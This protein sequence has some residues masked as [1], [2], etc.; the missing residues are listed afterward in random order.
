ML[1]LE[2]AARELMDSIQR[3]GL[4]ASFRPVRNEELASTVNQIPLSTD[5]LKWYEIGAPMD[6]EIPWS[7]E[8]LKLCSPLSLV[9]LQEG[10]RWNVGDRGRIADGWSD[11]W[12]VIGDC[13]SD[14]IIAHTDK[15]ETPISM[16]VH[17]KGYWDPLSVAPSLAVF[18]SVLKTWV[19]VCLVN[20]SGT[21]L[22]DDD[23][24]MLPEVRRD[25]EQGFSRLL[26]D[27]R[28]KNL[29]LF[30]G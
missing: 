18:L 30:I 17:G 28:R 21:Y 7:A 4:P 1:S 5:L 11:S 26:D 14:P 6:V 27:E 16:A 25:L 19:D 10:Y 12:V 2:S 20:Y 24:E 8:T 15:I 13:I 9:E 22:D 29:W 3:A 23:C